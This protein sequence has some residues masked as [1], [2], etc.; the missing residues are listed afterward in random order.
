MNTMIIYIFFKDL[1][2]DSSYLTF[3]YMTRIVP[4]AKDFSQSTLNHSMEYKILI[5]KIYYQYSGFTK[6]EVLDLCS[7]NKELNFDDL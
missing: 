4:I 5:D 6:Q 7:K 1:I 2:R 3:A